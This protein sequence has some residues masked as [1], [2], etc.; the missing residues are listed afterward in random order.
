MGRC[1]VARRPLDKLGTSLYRRAGGIG[2]K[3]PI[4]KGQ[5]PET[6]DQHADDDGCTDDTTSPYSPTSNFQPPTPNFHIYSISNV[7]CSA[8]AMFW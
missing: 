5:Q 6:Y 2:Q 3:Y 8:V 7:N 4:K 1:S